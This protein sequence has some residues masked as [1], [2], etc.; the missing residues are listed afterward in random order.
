MKN[1]WRKIL[2]LLLAVSM[3]AGAAA[4]G[5]NKNNEKDNKDNVSDNTSEGDEVSYPLN[6]DVKLS[7]WCGNQ[8]ALA[9]DVTNWQA[10]PFHSG[11]EDKTGV[12][13]DWRWTTSGSDVGQTYQLLWV[14]TELPNMVF[15]KITANEAVLLLEDGLIYDL[16]EYLPKYAPNY[17]AWLNDP[18]NEAEKNETLLSDGTAYSVPSIKEDIYCQVYQGP[19]IRQDWLDECGLDT[20][21]T[22]EDWETVLTAFKEKYGATLSFTKA[23]M[24]ACGGIASGTGAYGFVNTTD[25]RID[26]DGN[27]VISQIMPEYKEMMETLVRW[28]KAGLIDVD[29]LSNSDDSVRQKALS[30]KTGIVFVQAGQANQI[31][32]DAKADGNGANWVGLEYPRT[33]A[34][35]PT[36]MICT[37][38]TKLTGYHTVIT[39]QTSEEELIAALRW[40][41]Y[42]W[43]EEGRMYWNF[44]EEGISYFIDENGVPQ[45]SELVADDSLG[46]TNGRKK[47]CGVSGSASVIQLKSW[48]KASNNEAM[49]ATIEAWAANTV[50]DKHILPSMELSE[51]DN[52]TYNELWT[53][54]TTYVNEE[55]LKILTGES[56][57]SS[58]DSF[59]KKLYDMGLQDVLDIKQK[60]YDEYILK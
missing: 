7:Y 26:D 10:S 48:A 6:T 36:T 32:N 11:L 40:L 45:W 5:G 15:F 21:V 37:N 58:F 33:A 19:I 24:T 43:T 8:I 20:P 2:T 47:Y 16:T 14:D 17:W 51:D 25:F 57:I 1:L 3:I 46:L 39:T 31:M 13:I 30:G 50:A 56:S 38:A 59:I 23:I 49:D 42:G 60:Y 4:C 44:G 52:D 12:S 22:L 27:V 34:G 35:E 18:A 54:I 28:W 41:D 53:P 29:C 55:S 9:D